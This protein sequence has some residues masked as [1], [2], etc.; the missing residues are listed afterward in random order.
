MQLLRNSG[1]IVWAVIWGDAKRMGGG[2]RTRE[3][4]LPKIF[5]PVRGGVQNPFLGEVSFVWF[6]TPLFFPPPPSMASSE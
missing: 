5:G 3:R 1:A 4:A 6:S 2:K